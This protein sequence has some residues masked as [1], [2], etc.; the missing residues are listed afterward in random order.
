MGV[1]ANKFSAYIA[2]RAIN[3]GRVIVVIPGTEA[4][5]LA[6]FTINYLPLDEELARRFKLFG[7]K[8]MG[9]FVALPAATVLRQFGFQGRWL[10]QLAG[11]KDD[12]PLVPGAVPE[13]QQIY[14]EFDGRRKKRLLVKII[15]E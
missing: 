5:F 4:D 15:G 8:T 3:P 2:A 9:Q 14:Y 10:Q 7:L 1:A 12:R 11:G 6:P 13:I